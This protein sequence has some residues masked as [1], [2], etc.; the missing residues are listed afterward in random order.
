MVIAKG[1]PVVQVVG[2]TM[3]RDTHEGISVHQ[4]VRTKK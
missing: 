4:L 1:A 3:W 2:E